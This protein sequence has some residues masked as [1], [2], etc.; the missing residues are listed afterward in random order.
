MAGSRREFLQRSGLLLT[1]TAGAGS[2]LLTPAQAYAEKIP[3]QILSA[4]E[5]D[6]LA[7]IAEALVP[8]ATDAGISHFVDHQLAQ[9]PGDCLL[10][11][12]Y[13]GVAPADFTGFYQAA[14]AAADGLAQRLHNA[15]WGELN[16]QQTGQLLA[17]ISGPDPDGWQGPPAGFFTFVLRS[18]ACD[19]VYGTEEGFERIGMPYMAHIKPTASW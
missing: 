8:G 7:A 14:L 12:K 11:L 5:A 15:D 6:T 17:A 4:T 13:L 16:A 18:D 1:F 2:L 9:A 19:V 10:M 3:L